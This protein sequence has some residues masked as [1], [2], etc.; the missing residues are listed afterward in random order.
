M[1]NGLSPGF[2]LEEL[3]TYRQKHNIELSYHELFKTGPPHDSRFTFQVR[4]GEQEFPAAEG[5]SKKEAKNAAAKVALDILNKESKE[6]SSLSLPTTGTSEGASIGN[7]IGLINRIAQ[8]KN[9]PVNYEQYEAREPG[10]KRFHCK[11]K[12]GQKG[13]GSAS[14][15]TKQE[16]KQ[17]AAKLAYDQII[18]EETSVKADN[19]VSDSFSNVSSD[20]RSNS[21]GINTSSSEFLSEDNFS[22][23]TP[24]RQCNSD[25]ISN[26]SSSSMNSLTN[27]Q[28]KVKRNLA[29]TFH[30]PEREAN[31]YTK[32]HRFA[33]DFEEIEPIGTGGFGQVFKAKHR[34]DEKTYVIKRVR[35][36]NEKVEREVKALANLNHVNIVHYHSCWDGM[37]YDPEKSINNSRSM[38]RCLFIQMEYCDKG[39]LEQWI[40]NRRGKNSDKDLALNF[41]E[42]ITTGVAYIH[43]KQLIHR[44]LKP[45]NI[46][47]VDFEKIKIGDFGLVTSLKS[48]EKRTR[49]RG[50]LRYMSPEQLASEEYGNEVDLFALGLILAELLHKCI[51]F[52]ET[53][54]I[55]DDLRNGIFPDVFDSQ[56]KDLLQKLLSKEPKLRPKAPEILKTLNEWKIRPEKKMRN[57][58]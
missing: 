23:N 24:E 16:A 11:C 9:L 6:V 7:Y 48:N 42:Q 20:S 56:E 44:D 4:I 52:Q 5:K 21:S 31:K 40:E 26:F 45:S 25:N 30:N 49:K 50:T 8:K 27:N 12:I 53:L 58:C 15:A 14:G 29:P 38:R 57:T 33:K 3:N 41:F 36:D 47:L 43:S 32:D 2:F 10:P 51:S 18:S 35:Y 22:E 55:F 54:K 37:D 1:A 19:L 39:T 34:I 28:K 13:F 46:F 17:F